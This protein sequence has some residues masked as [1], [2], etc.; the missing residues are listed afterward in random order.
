MF[1]HRL[2]V[3]SH[4]IHVWLREH[5]G[6]DTSNQ[7]DDIMTAGIRRTRAVPYGDPFAALYTFLRQPPVKC[8]NGS[9]VDGRVCGLLLFARNC[10]I[11]AMSPAEFQ[12]LAREWEWTPG[13]RWSSDRMARGRLVLLCPRYF[14]CHSSSLGWEDH[15]APHGNIGSR[16]WV[17][18]SLVMLLHVGVKALLKGSWT[19]TLE[20]VPSGFDQWAYARRETC[21]PGG[22]APTAQCL[23]TVTYLPHAVNTIE[24][25]KP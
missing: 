13:T 11:L 6:S 2:S 20:R 17:C 5:K 16:H 21:N 9:P 3:G 19:A 22:C 8:V 18:G 1:S 4:G 12:R 14:G 10:W 23:P 7:L 25:E 15:Y 24:A